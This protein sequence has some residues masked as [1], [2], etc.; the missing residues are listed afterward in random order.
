MVVS[1]SAGK[2]GG[3]TTVPIQ[4]ATRRLRTKSCSGWTNIRSRSWLH[5]VR[6]LK[7][8]KNIPIVQR[9]RAPVHRFCALGLMAVALL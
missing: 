4:T 7:Q 8:P 6:Q 3:R 2:L 9:R 1:T 5:A